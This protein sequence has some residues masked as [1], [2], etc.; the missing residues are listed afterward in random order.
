MRQR[1]RSPSN[2]LKKVFAANYFPASKIIDV[3]KIERFTGIGL[4]LRVILLCTRHCLPRRRYTSMSDNRAAG[5]SF[6]GIGPI[7]TTIDIG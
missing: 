1:L 5:R 6:R 4:T 7:Q 3:A 2:L